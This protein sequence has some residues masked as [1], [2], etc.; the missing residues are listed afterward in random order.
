MAGSWFMRVVAASRSVA[1]TMAIPQKPFGVERLT[2]HDERPLIQ[3]G[4]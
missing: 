4:P 1:L 3:G 2:G